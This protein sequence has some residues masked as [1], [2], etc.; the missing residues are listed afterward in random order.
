MPQVSLADTGSV[1]SMAPSLAGSARSAG[2]GGAL[3]CSAASDVWEDIHDGDD[4]C[5]DAEAQWPAELH[6]HMTT[7]TGSFMYMAPEVYLSRAYNEKV[8]GARCR[9]SRVGHGAGG[10]V[11][12]IVAV[13]LPAPCELWMCGCWT[14]SSSSWVTATGFWVYNSSTAAVPLLSI[15]DCNS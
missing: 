1:Y 12:D 7:R 9:A 10:R 5:L 2:A 11:W 8:G 4:S 15:G 3:I 6:F 14:G 13:C